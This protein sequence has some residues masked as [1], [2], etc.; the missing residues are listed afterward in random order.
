MTDKTINRRTWMTGVLTTPLL[1]L[2]AS[3]PDFDII[4][5]HTHFYDPTR[6]EGIPWPTEGPLHRP[7]L[8]KHLRAL[9]PFRP[10][11]GTVIVEASSRIEDNAWLLNLAKDD[12]FVVGIVGRLE[13]G[14]P[15]FGQQLKRFGADPLFRGIRI[16]TDLLKKLLAADT[17]SDLEALA[18]HDLALDVNG[19]PETPSVLAQL[20]GRLPQLRIVLNHIGNVAVTERPPQD[21]WQEGIRAA[22]AHPNI[23]CKISALVE[24]AAHHTRK[25]APHALAF[26]RPY[27]DVVWNAFGDD[28]VIYG[29]NWPVSER[30][31]PYEVLQRIALEYAFAKGDEATRKFCAGNARQAYKWMDRPGRRQGR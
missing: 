11:T 7:V 10:V 30:G 25:P 3:S 15:A 1:G 14:D 2:A 12:P 31:A 26:Y 8:P 5:C 24:S 13:P 27:L 18:D 17:L 22:A 20:A 19:G 28:R 6:P 9:K 16:S 21:N 29:S 4:D 23:F